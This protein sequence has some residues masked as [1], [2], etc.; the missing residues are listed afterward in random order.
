MA[1]AGDGYRVHVTGLTHDEQGYPAMNWQAQKK[2]VR[3]LVSKI[4]DNAEHIARWEEQQSGGRR[5]GRGGV[6]HHL[7]R[8]AAGRGDGAGGKSCAWACCGPMVAWPFP[9]KRIRELAARS[10]RF[11]VVEMNLGQ[12]VLRG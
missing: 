6:R 10:T 2:L 1:K 7:A 4:R 11:L 9:E 12:M 5:R 3:R 8:G